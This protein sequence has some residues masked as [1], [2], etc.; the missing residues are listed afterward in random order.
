MRITK[1][2]SI[3]KIPHEISYELT[4]EKNHNFIANNFIKHN[5]DGILCKT[6][7]VG[8][9][10]YFFTNGSFTLNA[11]FEDSLVFDEPKTR[12]ATTYG[13]LL[14]AA[15]GNSCNV[16]FDVETGKFTATG[17]FVDSIP[18]GS[19]LMLELT[20]PRNKIICEYKETKLWWHGYRDAAGEE[21]DPRTLNLGIP[22][23][24]P[25]LYDAHN[26]NELK[27]ILKT[28]KGNEQEGVVVVDY[29][30]DNV[31]RTKIK[32]DDYLKLK[33]ARDTSCN[34][35]LLFKAI[36]DNEYDDLVASVPSLLPHIEEIK[37]QI[38][39]FYDWFLS[40]KQIVCKFQLQ[41]DFVKWCK[42]N[43]NP[44]LFK[45]YMFMK[46]PNAQDKLEKALKSLSCKKKGY[47]EFTELVNECN[48]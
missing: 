25:K 2:K 14:K 21:H 38:S 48:K 47:Q 29:S 32:C 17:G 15:L 6:A 8:N 11:P 33:F 3:K 5:C 43:T 42:T 37:K 23:E 36:M 45:Y 19:T 35:K 22:F 10:L 20:S 41:S 34:S 18:A 4:V 13:D 31:P 30:A 40:E 7:K 28:F 44:K 1:I 27:E 24:I 46:H 39:T 16:N 12:G 26:Y 9:E